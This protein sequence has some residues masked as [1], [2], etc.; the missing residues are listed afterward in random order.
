MVI[1]KCSIKVYSAE[2]LKATRRFFSYDWFQ[3]QLKQSEFPEFLLT[4]GLATLSQ[5]LVRRKNSQAILRLLSG[6][7]KNAQ[8]CTSARLDT[9]VKGHLKRRIK[10]AIFVRLEQPS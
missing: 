4:S 1:F 9:K 5:R 10:E 7:V 2:R 8:T 3:L 6:A